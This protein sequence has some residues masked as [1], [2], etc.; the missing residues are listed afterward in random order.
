[1]GA[2]TCTHSYTWFK[3][4]I[5]VSYLCTYTPLDGTWP[6]VQVH[7]IRDTKSFEPHVQT[8]YGGCVCVGSM[9]RVCKEVLLYLCVSQTHILQRG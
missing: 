8:V 5:T 9:S 6:S 7:L 4:I 1:M 3:A 2:D